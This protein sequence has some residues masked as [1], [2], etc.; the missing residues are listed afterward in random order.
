MMWAT[1]SAWS[2]PYCS[3][4]HTC[5]VRSLRAWLTLSGIS[6]GPLWR[7]IDRHGNVEPGTATTAP[8]LLAWP[9]ASSQ[10]QDT[11]DLCLFPSGGTPTRGC[12]MGTK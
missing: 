1:E 5:L 8:A 10:R 6:Y 12:R 2:R 4:P 3:H 7:E 11:T 9:R